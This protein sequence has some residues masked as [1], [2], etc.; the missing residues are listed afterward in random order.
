[1]QNEWAQLSEKLADIHDQAIKYGGGPKPILDE[2]AYLT[3]YCATVEQ[4]E[5]ALDEYKR[6]EVN[7]LNRAKREG[8]MTPSDRSRLRGYLKLLAEKRNAKAAMLRYLK[9]E[10]ES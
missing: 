2:L 7:A 8:K 10:I 3:Q 4:R 9:Q 1:M 5:A 6:A